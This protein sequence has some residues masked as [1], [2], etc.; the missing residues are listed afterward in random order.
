MSDPFECDLEAR[1]ED[2]WVLPVGD[3]DLAATVEFEEALALALASDARSIVVDL[4]GLDL[5]D[6]SGLRAL[7]QACS[8]EGGERLGFVQGNEMVQAVLRISGLLDELPFRP[9]EA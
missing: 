6:S 8:A 4:R 1:G 3:L 2:V 7:L 9:A 5:L